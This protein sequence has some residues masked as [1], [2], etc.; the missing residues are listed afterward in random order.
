MELKIDR[1][2]KKFK[3][4]PAVDCVHFTFHE[5]VYGLLGING[6][7]KTTLINMLTT[8]LKP[9]SGE[10]S[11]DGEDIFQMGDRYRMLLGYLPQDFGAYPD[12]S[13]WDYLMYIALLKGLAPANAKKRVREVMRYV[14]LQDYTQKKIKVLSGGMLRRVGIAQAILNSPKI[15]ILDE[16][17][18]GLDPSE[19]IRF[20]NLISELAHDRIVLLSTHI[21][22]DVSSIADQ[23]LLMKDGRFLASGTVAELV[24]SSSLRAWTC[25]CNPVQTRYLEKNH[26][27]ANIRSASGGTEVRVLAEDRPMAEAVAEDMTLEDVFLSYMGESSGDSTHGIL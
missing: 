26:M 4:M 14:G 12:F 2:T 27:V 11:W 23:I 8:L 5:G 19:R 22:S 10:I 15:L 3:K 21:V 7:G 20:R 17:T 18:V 1:L 9:S 24:E 16:P 13:L 6:A 25:L